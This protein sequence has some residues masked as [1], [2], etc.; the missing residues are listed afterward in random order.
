MLRI[1]KLKSGKGKGYMGVCQVFVGDFLREM[2]KANDYACLSGMM[3]L[4][5]E[6]IISLI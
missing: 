5:L 6:N 1:F 3:F 2:N 4:N